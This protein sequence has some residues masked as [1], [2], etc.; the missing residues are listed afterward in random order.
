MIL[1]HHRFGESAFPST[2]TTLDQ[3]DDHITALQHG[4]H[5]VLPLS[6]VFIAL[7]HVSPLPDNTVA[8][9]VD[10]AYRPF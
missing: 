3:L 7:R 2:S 10:D 8:I 9:D 4:G 6:D 5:T 1:M